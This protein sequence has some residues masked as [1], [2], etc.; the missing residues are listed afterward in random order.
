MNATSPTLVRPIPVTYFGA[1][2]GL[3]GL[4][5]G[6]RVA[7]R[8]WG[9][10]PLVGE[11]LS[12]TAVAIWASC[13][14]LFALGWLRDPQSVGSAFRDPTRSGFAALLPVSTLIASLG[15]WPHAPGI[16][17]IMLVTA[18]GAQVILA[19]VATADLW[20]G[21]RAPD[22]VTPIVLMPTIGGAFV[23]AIAAGQMGEAQLGM[24][25]LGAG[26]FSWIV[27]ESVVL[28]RLVTEELPPDLRATLG[29]HLTPP[30][31]ACVAYLAVTEG[32]PDR[33]AQMLFGYALLQGLVMLRLIPWLRAQGFSH[34]AW[35]YTFGVS[36]MPLAALRLVELGQTGPVA[37]L[38]LPLFAGAN[39]IIGWIAL[40][41]AGL[42]WRA[43]AALRKP[44]P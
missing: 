15:L 18:M 25:F 16:A 41:S 12:L 4:G 26:L 14:L 2:L 30:A 35:A 27:T 5:N 37:G 23:C 36:A 42:G 17:R 8:I 9:V 32:P 7:H 40:R 24:L 10:T 20:R 43:V 3:G 1:V 19:A 28:R 6:W 39:L 29:I 22:T 21:G 11:A 13:A 33:F 44:V 31:L 34:R 38:A